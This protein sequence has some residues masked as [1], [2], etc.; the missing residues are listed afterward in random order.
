MSQALASVLCPSI[1]IDLYDVST[2]VEFMQL[3]G[4]I[5]GLKCAQSGSILVEGFTAEQ[6]A[7]YAKNKSAIATRM[8]KENGML[9]SRLVEKGISVSQDDP[10][11]DPWAGKTLPKLKTNIAAGSTSGQQYSTLRRRIGY[12]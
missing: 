4:E 7:V 5:A 12:R 3:T 2:L 11:S 6:W 9:K 8:C 10:L 1:R